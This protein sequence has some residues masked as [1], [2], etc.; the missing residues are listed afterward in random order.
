MNLSGGDSVDDRKIL[1]VGNC[2][3]MLV[4]TS[5]YYRRQALKDGVIATNA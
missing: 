1:A 4:R 3:E 5:K 2:Q